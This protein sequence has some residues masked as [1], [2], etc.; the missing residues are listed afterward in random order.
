MQTLKNAFA[1]IICSTVLFVSFSC[2]K[3]E[4]KTDGANTKTVSAG[5]EIRKERLA[6][7]Q[8]IFN[9]ASANGDAYVALNATYAM[10]ADDTGNTSK[11]LD[12]LSALYVRLNLVGPAM[13]VADKILVRDPDNEKMLDL[14]ANAQM[15]M[16]NTGEA[17][18]I[19]RKLYEKDKKLKYLFQIA[20]VQ[21]SSR[22]FKD[23]EATLSQIEKH[24][25]L[26]TDSLEVPTDQPGQVQKVPSKAAVA[27]V[28]G[29]VAGEKQNFP[30]AKR[31]FKQAVSI[32]PRFTMA[33]KYLE[34]LNN[35]QL[36]QQQMQQQM[37]QQM[38]GQ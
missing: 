20:S 19:N 36:Q 26:N 6:F 35:P 1:A 2:T 8:R 24:P 21:L 37:P 32:F 12:T 16:G 28:R 29:V 33:Q 27:Y 23:L 25:D 38:P 34:M 7:N 31:K 9:E 11:Y 3:T 15:S 10:L 4:T 17:M 22:S 14:R 13:K 18:N 30:E 5:D